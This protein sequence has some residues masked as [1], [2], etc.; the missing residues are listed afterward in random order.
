MRKVRSSFF[1]TEGVAVCVVCGCDDL[2][3]CPG[4]CAWAAVDREKRK[5]TCTNCVGK[6]PR[7]AKKAKGRR[8]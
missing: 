5:G 8:R 3:A 2:H 7:R 6:R 4:G 1:D